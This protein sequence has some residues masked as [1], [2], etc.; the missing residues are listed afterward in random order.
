LQDGKTLPKGPVVI[1]P[2]GLFPSLYREGQELLMREQLRLIFIYICISDLYNFVLFTYGSNKKSSSWVQDCLSR[3]NFLDTNP[4]ITNVQLESSIKR[5]FL[6]NTFHVWV[7]MFCR[8]SKDFSLLII[9]H[10][11]RGL[12]I[13]TQMNLVTVK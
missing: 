13:E 6:T 5:H 4:Y 10:S 1:S 12:A 3:G 2:D 7:I 9:T 11:M 8:I